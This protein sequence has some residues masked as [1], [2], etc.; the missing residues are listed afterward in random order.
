MTG[1][2]EETPA[3]NSGNNRSGYKAPP[4]YKEGRCYEDWRLDIDLW[5]EFTALPKKRRATAFLLELKEGKVK[6]H[7]RSLGKEV[8]MAEDGLEQIIARLDKIYKEDSSHIAYKIYCKFEQYERRDEMNLQS[9]ISEFEKLY[10]DLKKH[11]IELPEEVLAYRV[12]NSAKLAPEKVDLALATVKSMTYADMAKTIGKIFTRLPNT[13]SQQHGSETAVIKSE[14]EE[15]NFT[16]N[17][18]WRRGSRGG[19]RG[20]GSYSGPYRNNRGTNR[21]TSLPYSRD[22]RTRFNSGCFECGEKGHIVRFCP[23]KARGAQYFTEEEMESE[24]SGSAYVTLMVEETTLIQEKPDSSS[25]VFETL[26]C[27]V[28]D[29]GCTKTVVGRNW[30]EQYA[31]TLGEEERRMMTPT[32]YATPF[33]FGDG[34]KVTS[35]EKIKIPGR[36]GTQKI[37]IDANV[38]SCDLPLLLSKPSLKKA[39]AVIDFTKDTMMFNGEQVKL[40]EC[41]SGHYCVPLCNRRRYLSDSSVQLVLTVTEDTMGGTDEKEM[42]K[43]ALKLHRQ[44]AHAPAYKL[45]SMLR[46]AG[47]TKK[48]FM[49]AL[50]IVCSNCEVCQRYAKPKPRP[51][52][53]LPRGTVFN[54]CVAMDLK[55]VQ[56]Q[57]TFIHMIDCATRFSVAKIIPNKKKETVVD[58]VCTSWIALF[59]SP[60]RFMADNGGEFSNAEYVE[61]CEQFNVE[62]QQSAAESPFSNGMVERHHRIIAEMMV[63]TREDVRCTWEVSLAWAVSAK[64]SLQM[65]GGYSPYQLVLGKN[66]PLPNVVDNHLPALEEKVAS[67]HLEDNLRAMRTAR[68]EFIKAENSAKIKRALRSQVRT[69]QDT[70]LE[71]GEKVLYKRNN[72][73]RWNGPGVV[74]GRDGQTFVVKH[75]FQIVKVHPCHISKK[76]T[77]E[78]HQFVST[79]SNDGTEKRMVDEDQTPRY[80]SEEVPLEQRA[81]REKESRIPTTSTVVT[82]DTREMATQDI[83]PT[84][85]RQQESGEKIELPKVKTN[86]LF[87]AKYP[88]DGEEETW[89][90]V[91]I[92]SRGGK[93]SG[94][95]AK[96]L[97]IQLDGESTIQCVDWSELA[98]EWHVDPDPGQDQEQ[99]QE[100]MFTSGEMFEQDIVDAKIAE[101]EKFKRNEV[102]DEV[103]N[104]GQSTIGVRWVVTRKTTGE[105][106]ARLVALGYQERDKGLRA[107]SP[108]CSKDTIRIVTMLCQGLK[109]LIQHIDVQAAFLQGEQLTRTLFIKPPKEASTVMLWKLKKCIYG[110]IDGPRKW[111]IALRRTLEDLGMTVSSYDESFFFGHQGEELAGLIAIHVDDLM[112]GGNEW[113]LSHV[114][115]SLKSKFKL[116]TEVEGSFVYTGLDIKQS[117]MLINVSQFGYIEQISEIKIDSARVKLNDVP[118]N[119][120]EK[121]QLRSAAGQL[122]WVATQTRPDI[123]YGTCIA[124]NSYSSGTVRD[125]KLVNKTIRFMKRNPLSLKFPKIQFNGAFIIVFSDASFGNLSDGSSQG[126]HIIFMAEKSG[127][128][129]PLTWQSRKI[130]KV[131]K[132]TL[133][134]ESWALVDALDAAELIS[135]QLDQIFRGK[136]LFPIIGLTD[137]KSLYDAIRTTNSLE[138]KGLRIPM[139]CLRQ[140]FNRKEVKFVWVPTGLQLADCL[141]KAGASSGLLRG[142]IEDGKLPKAV[143]ALLFNGI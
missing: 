71:M 63:K 16:Y 118:I 23:K 115:G 110:L 134:A 53:G 137:C 8:L 80:Y 143:S 127:K 82:A 132:S 19:S 136:G 111:Y 135:T 124:A 40:L 32:E 17:N 131:C 65:S 64:N 81:S 98:S 99:E 60:R 139:A 18:N 114:M 38:V 83:V 129:C 55:T 117:F 54:D 5:S 37:L 36:I 67:R 11:K 29:S 105:P 100:V 97:N 130:R 62:L 50:E 94:K 57:P 48:E 87:R 26:S 75:G 74:I 141:T 116:S 44:F 39:G 142:T 69:C 89:E 68:E 59:G 138:D 128:C 126:G 133:G 9:Y 113:F 90:K 96:C 102:Y 43:K 122:L 52:V 88:E 6:N 76:T 4:A 15:C 58:A 2:T 112:F 72:S 125:L 1:D 31:E 121:K 70:V 86:V 34:K 33:K 21:G 78:K 14:P 77:Q 93:A 109:W 49:K 35:V 92:H 106:K 46:N 30:V 66:P 140:R 95:Y 45:Q 28:I 103:G 47:F 79:E 27:A 25:L 41:K 84:A 42:K 91:Y 108:T 3:P 12:L 119:E 73:D 24:N 7:V 104:D 85:S 13:D 123:S 10:D 56:G 101:L 20:S 107:D 61:M 120:V 51:V 22:A